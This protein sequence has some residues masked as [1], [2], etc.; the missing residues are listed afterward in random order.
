MTWFL[1]NDQLKVHETS[2]YLSDL[3]NLF[4]RKYGND[5]VPAG[6]SLELEWFPLQDHIF[7]GSQRPIEIVRHSG[8][9]RTS[10]ID[11]SS[12]RRNFQCNE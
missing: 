5:Q 3:F 8:I 12:G 6:L 10:E 2:R 11:Y 1:R 4:Q 9:S 7:V